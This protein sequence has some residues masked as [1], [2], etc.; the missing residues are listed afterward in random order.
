[1]EKKD[2]L[3]L[4]RE[5]EA[6]VTP[7]EADPN[8]DYVLDREGW[9]EP[10]FEV[11]LDAGSSSDS[12]DHVGRTWRIRVTHSSTQFSEEYVMRQVFDLAET[13]GVHVSIAN[14]GLELT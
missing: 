13:A 5:L 1:M 4:F 6:A 2:A 10:T 8:A 14:N 7:I 12:D 3:A 11:R 9:D